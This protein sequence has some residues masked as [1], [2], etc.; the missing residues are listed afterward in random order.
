MKKVGILGGSGFIGSYITK[1]FLENGFEVKVSSTHIS[2]KQKY[3]NLREVG[4]SKH[5]QISE[6]NMENK[7]AVTEFVKECEIVVHGGTHFNSTYKI[8]K[9]N[10]L[11]SNESYPVSDIGLMLNNKAPINKAKIIY[12]NAKAARKLKIPFQPALQFLQE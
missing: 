8:Q 3:Q 9:Q 5:L 7:T 2:K 4:Y 6:L 12:Q 11:F 1:V 10:Y